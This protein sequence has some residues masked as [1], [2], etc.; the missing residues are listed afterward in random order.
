MFN[1]LIILAGR[2]SILDLLDP[3]L[4]LVATWVFRLSKYISALTEK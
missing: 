4:F 3:S 1:R 2:T